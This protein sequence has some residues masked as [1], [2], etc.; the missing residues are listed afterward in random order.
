MDKNNIYFKY[1]KNLRKKINIEKNLSD[2]VNVNEDKKSSFSIV[3]HTIEISLTIAIVTT[4]ISFLSIIDYRNLNKEELKLVNPVFESDKFLT[5]SQFQENIKFLKL[6]DISTGLLED[7][8]YLKEVNSNLT[9]EM[10]QNQEKLIMQNIEIGTLINDNKKL[11]SLNEIY[12]NLIF[13]FKN[14][15][16]NL[17]S[18][19]LKYNSKNQKS[20]QL[21]E[22]LLALQSKTKIQDKKLL[23]AILMINELKEE[24]EKLISQINIFPPKEVKIS[25][26]NKIEIPNIKFQ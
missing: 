11:E 2:E 23:T 14:Q 4:L 20:K 19:E 16:S 6:K 25:N 10:F 12:H 13:K 8:I 17:M 3:N 18:T 22:N 24:K 15:K 21:N 5:L 7:A 9:R 1:I 26:N